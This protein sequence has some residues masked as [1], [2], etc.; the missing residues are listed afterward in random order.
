MCG[1]AIS[2]DLHSPM[3]NQL[4]VGAHGLIWI[5]KTLYVTK[6][7]WQNIYEIQKDEG[8][9]IKYAVFEQSSIT[10][11]QHIKI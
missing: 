1:M 9:I 6:L 4:L 3:P 8:I 10:Y 7:K 2:E 11:H 5:H